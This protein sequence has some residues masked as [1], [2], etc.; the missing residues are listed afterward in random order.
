RCHHPRRREKASC[1]VRHEC[2]GVDNPARASHGPDSFRQNRTD[3]RCRATKTLALALRAPEGPYRAG[4]RVIVGAAGDDGA[5]IVRERDGETERSASDST[6]AG[7]LAAEL[8]PARSGAAVEPGGASTRVV[9][10]CSD[11]RRLAVGREVGAVS[12]C[13][14]PAPAF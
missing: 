10:R 7:E 1:T 9:A 6:S 14:A 2:S 3:P 11:H 8:A 13:P 4:A 12:K 5:R